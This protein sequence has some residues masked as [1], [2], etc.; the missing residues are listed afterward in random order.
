MQKIP[1]L[2]SEQPE[3][4]D[5]ENNVT[6]AMLQSLKYETDEDCLNG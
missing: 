1:L 4:L 2:M 5:P 3:N 6:L